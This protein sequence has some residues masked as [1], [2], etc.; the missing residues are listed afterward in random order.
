MSRN[1][2]AL[3]FAVTALAAALVL[4]LALRPASVPVDTAPVARGPLRVTIDGIG[5]TRVRERFVVLAPASG[6][7]TRVD[8]LPGDD[9]ERGDLLAEVMASTPALL[10]GRTQR[11]VSAR[12]DAARAAEAEAA[13]GLERARLAE[14]EAARELARVS[15]LAAQ[16]A[17]TTQQHDAA[18]F[19]ARGRALERHMAEAT[20]RRAAGERQALAATLQ[21]LGGA[22]AERLL[23]A[24]PV[25]ATVLRVLRTD[26]GPVSAGAAL[27]ELGDRADLEV[28]VD[29]LTSEAVRV[30]PGAKV[31]LGG[32]GGDRPLAGVVARIE[33][34]AFTKVSALGVEEQRV[35]VV[36]APADRAAGF[37]PLGDGFTVDARI[38]VDERHEALKVPASALVREG[39]RWAV[40]AVDGGVARLTRVDLG[41]RG[42]GEAEVLA[43]LG[44]GAHVVLYPSD[45]L[46]DGARVRRD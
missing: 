14:A 29:L 21:G 41:A 40:F 1:R 2:R 17:M 30:R 8:R 9:V 10:D 22:G 12:L 5:K 36:I 26:A 37:A 46:D 33:P 38:V 43:G 31:E 4:F 20:V 15:G 27:V 35:N 11:E 7:L 39:E 3:V 13:A 6:E 34:S 24:A 19:A 28:V 44:D 23:V 45:R 18:S 16:G 42:R 25:A 32:W